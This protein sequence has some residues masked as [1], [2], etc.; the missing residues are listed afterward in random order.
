MTKRRSE[1]LHPH[2]QQRSIT[3]GPPL[4][5]FPT[6]RVD[7]IGEISGTQQTRLLFLFFKL[8]VIS[9]P[10]TAHCLHPHVCVR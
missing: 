3:S 8:V 9:F 6:S 5:F 7:V 4:F 1:T 10:K 2:L